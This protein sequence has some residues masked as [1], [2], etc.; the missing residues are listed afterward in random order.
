MT[1]P[2]E[3]VIPGRGRL[4]LDTLLLDINGTLAD[5]GY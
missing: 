3:V 4:S 1:A 2:I 5:R